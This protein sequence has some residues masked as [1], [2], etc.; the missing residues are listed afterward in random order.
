MDWGGEIDMNPLCIILFAF[1]FQKSSALPNEQVHRNHYFM[2]LIHLHQLGQQGAK[3]KYF[4]LFQPMRIGHISV[5]YITSMYL[6]TVEK[7][8]FC[9]IEC[10]LY[11][12]YI[13]KK[14]IFSIFLV[15]LIALYLLDPYVRRR[16]PKA[17]V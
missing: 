1:I 11:F 2:L 12:L 4:I 7:I 9:M 17:H 3:I 16:A 6:C 10:Y 15:E 14:N 13:Y 5:F 8:Y